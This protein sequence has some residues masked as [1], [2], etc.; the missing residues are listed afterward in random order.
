MTTERANKI[1]LEAAER[2]ILAKI[3]NYNNQFLQQVESSVGQGNRGQTNLVSS[4]QSGG[5]ASS[6]E[7]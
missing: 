6:Q 7:N 4:G 5:E 2:N 3:N 1:N